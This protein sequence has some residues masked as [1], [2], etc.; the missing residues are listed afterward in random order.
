[1][2]RLRLLLVLAVIAALGACLLIAD[3][4]APVDVQAPVTVDVKLDPCDALRLDAGLQDAGDGG[5][6]ECKTDADCELGAVCVCSQCR[7]VLR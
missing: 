6:K 4:D 2:L 7:S 1:M 5:V 3:V